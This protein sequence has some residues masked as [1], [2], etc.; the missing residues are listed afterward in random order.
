MVVFFCVV[1]RN[2]SKLA[3]AGLLLW[4][5]SLWGFVT[6]C[7]TLKKSRASSAF[8]G[9]SCKELNSKCFVG[10]TTEYIGWP[11]PFVIGQH[12]REKTDQ[13]PCN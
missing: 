5:G 1:S 13:F 12:D 9:V 7:I 3:C 11:R 4:T 10:T 2:C 8:L 6:I